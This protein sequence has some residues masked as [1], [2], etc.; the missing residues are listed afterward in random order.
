[1]QRLTAPVRQILLLSGIIILFTVTPPSTQSA[2]GQCPANFERIGSLQRSARIGRVDSRLAIPLLDTLDPDSSYQQPQ[3]EGP[4]LKE[5]TSPRGLHLIISG[6]GAWEVSNPR[7]LNGRIFEAS[8]SCESGHD[9]SDRGC[10]V[11]VDVCGHLLKTANSIPS[12]NTVS[13]K[14]PFD[15]GYKGVAL[16]IGNADYKV[17]ELSLN[18]PIEDAKGMSDALSQLGWK[19]ILKS[20]LDRGAM[21]AVLEQY[22]ADLRSGEVGLFFYSGHGTQV[23]GANYLLPIDFRISETTADNIAEKAIS[24]VSIL[25]IIRASPTKPN[26]ILLDAC[27][28]NPFSATTQKGLSQPNG[29]PNQSIIGFAA[30]FGSVATEGESDVK[31]SAYTR[32]ILKYLRQPGLQLEDFFKNVRSSVAEYTDNH[33]NPREA[34][35]VFTSFAFRPSMFVYGSLLSGDDEVLILVNGEETLSWNNDGSQK[36]AIPL[37]LG[38][39]VITLKVYNQHTFTGGIE[40]LGGHLPEGWKY[41]A[42]FTDKSGRT[43]LEIADNEDVPIKDGPHHGKMFTAARITVNVDED[44]DEIHITKVDQNIWTRKD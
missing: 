1:M 19:V 31:Y 36:K 17:Q 7:L 28:D 38:E 6:Q 25:K 40:G 3:T 26:I 5:G 34:T 41:S 30:D 12:A 22:S 33:Q 32:A 24:L 18:D 2:V 35:G 37:K 10:S 39:N 21:Q 4:R 29:I 9:I 16:V 20:N 15:P 14:S 27:R 43:L 23:N 8:L 44:S 11:R 42:L 13:S